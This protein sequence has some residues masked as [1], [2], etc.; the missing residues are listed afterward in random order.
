M[1]ITAKRAFAMVLVAAMLSCGALLLG[2]GQVSKKETRAAISAS[3]QPELDPVS[4][5][6]TEREQLRAM[7]KAQLNDIAH[8]A[9]AEAEIRDMA[10]RQLMELCANEETELTIEGILSMRGFESPVVTVHSGSV[11]VLLR[12]ESITKQQSSVILD[13]VSRESGAMSGDI[14]IIPIN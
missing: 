8:D 4:Q 7:Q 14:K 2:A 1:K 13:L 3:E 9:Q 11:N 6:R 12:A 10:R 5:F